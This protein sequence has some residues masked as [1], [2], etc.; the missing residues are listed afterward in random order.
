MTVS[1]S[2]ESWRDN[3]DLGERISQGNKIL[4]ECPLKNCSVFQHEMISMEEEQGKVME[5]TLHQACY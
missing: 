2:T 1:A 5:G 4:H 3:H